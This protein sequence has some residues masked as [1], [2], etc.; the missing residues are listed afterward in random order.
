[1][2][3]P[4]TPDDRSVAR[5]RAL[6]G[7]VEAPAALHARIEA[8]QARQ[9]SRRARRRAWLAGGAVAVALAALAAALVVVLAPSEPPTVVEAAA[10]AG[11]GPAAPAPARDASDPDDL[12]RSVDGVAFPAW[13]DAVPYRA[14]GE[15]SDTIEGRQAATV[16]YSGPRGARVAYTI[17]AGPALDWPEGAR[18]AVRDGE[19]IW[20]LRRP[21]GVV[22]TWRELGHQCVLS[23]PASVPDD[24]V[25][26]LAARSAGRSSP[27][28][29][30]A[31]SG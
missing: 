11:R 5:M 10:L 13:S 25:L 1:M 19:E 9:A 21:G 22:A 12:A 23:A 14:V 28:Y 7:S 18:Q 24:A 17:V 26:T 27:G 16:Y 2:S 8:E 20:L 30:G 31:A 15:R 29:E 4:G 6:V 3:A